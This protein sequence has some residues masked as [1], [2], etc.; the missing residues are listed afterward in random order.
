MTKHVCDNRMYAE[1]TKGG[2]FIEIEASPE[3][4]RKGMLSLEVGW[5]CVVVHRGQ[6]PATWL[7]EIIAIATAHPGG[8]GGFLKDH[9]YGNPSFAL[10]CNP[11]A[12]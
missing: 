11:T 2:C 7:A 3:E 5:S 6:I 9:D 8:I 1:G 4:A 10:Q 12:E